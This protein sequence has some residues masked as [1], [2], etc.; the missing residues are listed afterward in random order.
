M[1]QSS[2]P[3]LW[4]VDASNMTVWPIVTQETDYQNYRTIITHFQSFK[5]LQSINLTQSSAM[6]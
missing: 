5:A 2:T 4:Q 1:H 6:V 3:V